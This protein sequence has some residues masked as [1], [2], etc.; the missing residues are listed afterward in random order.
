MS[1]SLQ[2]GSFFNQI[3]AKKKELNTCQDT[4]KKKQQIN[5][6][7]NFW[8]VS[9]LWGKFFFIFTFNILKHFI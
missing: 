9:F 1:S 6:K 4:G 3:L 8:P 7:D 5:T 2:L